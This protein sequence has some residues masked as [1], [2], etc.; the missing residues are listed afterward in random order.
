[1][2]VCVYFF[3]PVKPEL[4]VIPYN[5]NNNNSK[6]NECNCKSRNDCPM[7]GLYWNF[8]KNTQQDGNKFIILM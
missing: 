8:I 6:Q 1:M 3:G 5:N 4:G 2:C 7:N